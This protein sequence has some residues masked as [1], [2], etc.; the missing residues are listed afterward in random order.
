MHQGGPKRFFK[1]DSFYLEENNRLTLFL[2]F[3]KELM[4]LLC[5]CVFIHDRRRTYYSRRVNKKS[6]EP[7]GDD[8]S[9]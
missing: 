9:D 7:Y 6:K 4:I 2:L 1:F 3:L 5:V 8:S